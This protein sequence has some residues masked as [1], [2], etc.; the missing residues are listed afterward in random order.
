MR[1]AAAWSIAGVTWL[2]VSRVSITEECPSRS[3]MIFAGTPAAILVIS[4]VAIPSNSSELTACLSAI[5]HGW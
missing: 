2:Y 4:S 3:A 1:S 5:R